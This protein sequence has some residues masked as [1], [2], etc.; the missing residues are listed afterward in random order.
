MHKLWI[1]GALIGI[2]LTLGLA[3]LPVPAQTETPSRVISAVNTFRTS[4]GLPALKV[5]YAL[6]G[7]AQAHSDYQASISQVTHTG[8]NGSRPIDRAYAWGFGDG[9]TAFVSENIAG[10]YKVTVET[11]I[12]DF[13][14]DEAHLRTM[15]NPNAIYIGAGVATSGSSTY[16]TVVTGY[17]VGARPAPTTAPGTTPN[18]GNPGDPEPTLVAYEPFIISTPRGDGAIIHVVGYGQTLIGI[19]NS[20]GVDLADIYSYNSYNTNTVIYPNE[21]VIIRP[22]NEIYITE[23]PENTEVSGVPS[24]TAPTPKATRTPRNT[25]SATEPSADATK[26]T[27]IPAS[28]TTPMTISASEGQEP[29]V[30]GVV[31]LS[32]VVLVGV[33]FY[34][35]F[36][37]KT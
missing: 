30:V 21:W 33:I 28:T 9:A 3:P 5:D 8:A 13:W 32:L 37:R 10:G 24:K 36:N 23:T 1:I 26:S 12:Y 35:L 11:A 19:A 16:Y 14:Q 4:K 22:A 29:I 31:I 34:G 2:L 15:L 27:D 25:I 7:A 20:Y 6:M 17:Y 18:P